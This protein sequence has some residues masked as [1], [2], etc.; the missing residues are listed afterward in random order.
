[1]I[2]TTYDPDA[3]AVYIHLARGKV[4]QSEE[5]FR[6]VILDFDDAGRVLGIEVLDARTT[7]APGLWQEAPRPASRPADAAE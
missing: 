2:D 7:L 1:M 4:A 5:V 6:G 3:N